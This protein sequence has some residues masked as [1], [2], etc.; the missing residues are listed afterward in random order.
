LGLYICREVVEKHGGTI[1]VE[2]EVGRGSVFTVR[3]PVVYQ[4][5]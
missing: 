3:V 1:S 2:S 4:D 5:N